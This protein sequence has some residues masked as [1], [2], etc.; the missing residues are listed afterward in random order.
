MKFTKLRF[1]AFDENKLQDIV[2]EL[3]FDLARPEPIAKNILRLSDL[4]NSGK[5]SPDIW[6]DR[7]FTV[8]YIVYFH[9]LNVLRLTQI[10]NEARKLAFWRGID[11][12]FDFGAG[13]GGLYAALQC[14]NE[15]APS[16]RLY[17]IEASARAQKISEQLSLN[18]SDRILRARD[19]N[20]RLDNIKNPERSVVAFSYSYNEMQELHPAAAACEGL[21]FL[22]PSTLQFGRRL[23]NLRQTLIQ[24]GFHPWAPCLHHQSCPLLVHSNRDWCHSRIHVDLPEW[25]RRIEHH[26]PMKNQSL[27]FS[28]LLLRKTAPPSHEGS[29][30]RIIGD[31]LY[32]KGKTRQA[33]CASDRRE[34]FSWLKK[35]GEAPTLP[36]GCVVKVKSE[37]VQ[38]SD[39]LRPQSGHFSYD[40]E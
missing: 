23:Q 34:F 22:E 31:T 24:K 18:R 3:G 38:K 14:Q 25:F 13:A 28:Y 21:L 17:E 4:Y 30:W 32:E 20:Q 16:I 40:I 39:E 10:L 15:H 27:T 35:D 7:G 33:V 5:G 29:R 11:Q 12:V 26:L 9:T 19:R 8:A 36:R 6:D 2:Q 1:D 37:L